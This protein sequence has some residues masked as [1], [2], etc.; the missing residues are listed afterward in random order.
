MKTSLP[1]NLTIGLFIDGGYYVKV[2]EGLRH[3]YG[4]NL[5]LSELL[6]FIREQVAQDNGLS[7]NQ[8]QIPDAH[9]F[10]GRFKADDAQD[11]NLLYSEREF[12]DSLI[13][14]DIQF[15]Y[16][17]LREIDGRIV[18]K[19]I[20]VWFAL[21][22]LG[23]SFVNQF[24][25]VV[26]ITGDADHEMLIRKLKALKIKVILLTGNFSRQSATAKLLREEATIHL[27]LSQMFEQEE[28]LIKRLCR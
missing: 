6:L 10:R 23:R 25:Y 4:A 24:D 13:E 17:H 16:K 21:E 15:H 5:C 7:I 8:C 11:K 18:E 12:E 28:T 27:E 14:N 19:G 22:A 3:L 26:L 9:F 2:N 1:T 20:D